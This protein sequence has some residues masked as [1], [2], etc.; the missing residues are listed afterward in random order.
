M[1]EYISKVKLNDMTVTFLFISGGSVTADPASPSGM[2]QFF[3][4][5]Y[6]LWLI[7][8]NEIAFR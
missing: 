1:L 3:L 8:C 7:N 5:I 6:I 4:V 2:I